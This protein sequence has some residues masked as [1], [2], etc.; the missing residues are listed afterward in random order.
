MAVLMPWLSDMNIEVRGAT[1]RESHPSEALGECFLYVL[2]EVLPIIGT[3][4]S[5]QRIF[6]L[7]LL[8]SKNNS[9]HMVIHIGGSVQNL[10]TP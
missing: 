7:Y 6:L 10:P 9:I 4:N 3:N 8:L 2:I 5:Y 1:P